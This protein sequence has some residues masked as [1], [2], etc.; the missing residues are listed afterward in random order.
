[1]IGSS[2]DL[3]RCLFESSR[4][5]LLQTLPETGQIVDANP[6]AE[7]LTGLSR[8]HLVRLQLDDVLHSLDAGENGSADSES[9]CG[10]LGR[11]NQP[12]LLVTVTRHEIGGDTGPLEL[13]VFRESRTFQPTDYN[14]WIDPVIVTDAAGLIC[15]SNAAFEQLSGRESDAVAG[16]ALDELLDES[17]QPA[18][19]ERLRQVHTSEIES[20]TTPRLAHADGTPIDAEMWSRPVDFEG[21]PAALSV[22]RDL[23]DQKRVEAFHAGQM[24]ILESL[25]IDHDLSAVL[26]SL[27]E[28]IERLFVGTRA[29]VLLLDGDGLTLRHGAAPSLPDEYNAL[30]DGLSCGPCV[31]SCGT[32][33]HRK[34][35]VVVFDT[36]TDPLWEPFR[37]IAEQFEHRACWS[38]P[39][40]TASGEVLGTFALYYRQQRGPTSL[41]LELIENA[42]HLVGIAIQRSRS[43]AALRD[44]RNEIARQRRELEVILDA[45]QA[46]VVYMDTEARVVRHNRYSRE[47]L[48]LSDDD[49]RGLNVIAQAP[50]LDDPEL[51]HQQSLEVIRTGEPRL[52]SIES[53]D[54]ESGRRWVSIDK[55]PTF[56]DDG[57]VNG[58]LLFIYDI[59][60]LKQAEVLARESQE[61]FRQLAENIGSAF[62]MSDEAERRI[63]YVSPPYERIFGRSC[64][65]MYENPE[66]FLE[67]VAPEDRGRVQRKIDRQLAGEVTIE[68]YRIQRPD[69]AV[70]WVRDQAFPIRDESGTVVRVAGV[71]EDITEMKTAETRL[72]EHE[73]RLG[74]VA[75]LS[76]L[77]EM[78]A[79][80]VHELT[81]PL[82]ALR[83]YASVSFELAQR[84]EPTIDVA[85]LRASTERIVEQTHRAGDIVGRVRKLV[86]QSA[87]QREPHDLNEL[88][89]NTLSVME[90]DLRN[91]SV[92]IETELSGELSAVRVDSVQIEQLL[93]NL[94]RN[95]VDALHDNPRDDRRLCVSSSQANG[96]CR[97]AV[98]DNGP[99]FD[100]VDPENVFDMFFTTRAHGMGVGLSISRT[101]ARAHD[102]HLTAGSAAE[103]GAVFELTLPAS[104]AT[105][106]LV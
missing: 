18:I 22:F 81:Q 94:V 33:V 6:A 100:G 12:D 86:M 79:G 54:E 104:P 68:E 97:I 35:R 28:L 91:A 51:R 70:R 37:D 24:R 49:I 102:G 39:V 1:M 9:E 14:G 72:R 34:E 36:M 2:I 56:D 29:S 23:T 40:M 30:V 62:W 25:A 98:E 50:E 58:L 46:Q 57:D 83:N 85:R 71:T 52:G 92:Q 16:T 47:L 64:Q 5:G 32:A 8:E 78:A 74:R 77:G 84:D 7:Q 61:L 10:R 82:A 106:P 95:A 17:S 27:I 103:R 76:T 69:G 96:T 20:A 44:S 3:A 67:A 11:C 87:P 55:V 80:I 88:I 42:A 38:Q 45:V 99:G 31:G 60:Q 89:Q 21:Q 4:D 19:S 73:A 101:I 41:E 26:E 93:I 75:R 48:G 105:S 63:I 13:I 53:Y 90:T 59:T 66:Q 15:W 65:E 43:D